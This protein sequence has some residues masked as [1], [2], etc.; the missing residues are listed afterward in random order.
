VLEQHGDASSDHKLTSKLVVA[1]FYASF[2]GWTYFA[3]YQRSFHDFEVGGDGDWKIWSDK[4]WMS[5]KTYA[6]GADKMGHTWATMSLGRLGTEVL[7]M[8]GHDRL[9]SALV[10]NGLSELLFFGVEIGDGFQ[11]T[12]SQ[13]DFTFNTIGAILG[14]TQS[15]FPQFDELVSFRVAYFP[16][17]AYRDNVRVKHDL[18]IAEDY[19]GQTYLLDLHLGALPGL[20]DWKYG[21]WA[22]FVDF[23]LGF[24]T[25]G[26]KPDPLYKIDD[27]DPERMDFKKSQI[28][29]IG[30]S[31]NAQGVFD[32]LLRDHSHE[33]LRKTLHG[34]TE[35]FAVPGASLDL[36]DTTTHYKGDVPDDQNL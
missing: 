36:L 25:R 9:T 28:G 22:K 8:G 13:G 32:Y 14:F 35:V 10:G 15:V 12:F 17:K 33:M 11:Y 6:G 31:L 7:S 23:S 26:Y 5:E 19:S 4:G 34:M 20:R 18:D 24:K 1:G 30:F 21:T 27:T 29:F 3:W 2:I 16:S